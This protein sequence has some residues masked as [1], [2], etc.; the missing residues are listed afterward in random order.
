M[1]FVSQVGLYKD[2]DQMINLPLPCR[3]YPLFPKVHTRFQVKSSES[4]VGYIQ[5]TSLI[6]I[7]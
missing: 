7:I 5:M 2:P 4:V 6:V 3:I 1:S